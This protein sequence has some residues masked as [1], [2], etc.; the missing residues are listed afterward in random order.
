MTNKGSVADEEKAAAAQDIHVT[1]KAG[2]VDASDSPS[3]KP[4][5]LG[6]DE[7][8]P[9][10]SLKVWIVAV[11]SPSYCPGS[12]SR[13]LP[14]IRQQA[15]LPVLISPDPLLRIWPVVLAHSCR[16][17]RRRPGFRRLG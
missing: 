10:V 11:V 1:P 9:V 6:G 14:R 3:D 2:S 12:E 16:C 4:A 8:E 5:S 7:P 17:R 13:C 15:D